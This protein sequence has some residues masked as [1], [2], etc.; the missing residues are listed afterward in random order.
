MLLSKGRRSVE[1]A[2]VFEAFS[3]KRASK[4]IPA[5]VTLRDLIDSQSC[6]ERRLKAC[7]EKF[8]VRSRLSD[9]NPST[10]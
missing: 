4:G 3:S 1:A 6:F 9:K 5:I 10:N 2:Q 7:V 8:A